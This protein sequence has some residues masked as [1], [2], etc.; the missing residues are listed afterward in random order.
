VLVDLQL[1]TTRLTVRSMMSRIPAQLDRQRD[2]RARWDD[3]SGKPSGGC[4]TAGSISSV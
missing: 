3:S 1:E 4:G 2:C